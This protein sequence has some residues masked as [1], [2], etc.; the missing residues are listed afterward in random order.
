LHAPLSALNT[1]GEAERL[2]LI[3]VLQRVYRLDEP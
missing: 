3:A 1:A 2:E